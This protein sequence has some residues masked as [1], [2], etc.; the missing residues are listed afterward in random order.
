MIPP[1]LARLSMKGSVPMASSTN[2]M[3]SSLS[4]SSQALSI[5]CQTWNSSTIRTLASP[6][7]AAEAPPVT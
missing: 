1:I 7:T 6:K 4:N 5:I 3:A 2:I